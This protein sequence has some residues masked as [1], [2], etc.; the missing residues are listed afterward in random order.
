MRLRCAGPSLECRRRAVPGLPAA[1]SRV[2]PPRRV[3]PSCCPMR[4]RCAG[5]SLEC[6][7]RAVPGLPAARGDG[8]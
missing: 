3:R 7:R 6:R 2:P 5:P 4:L 1:R 8:C